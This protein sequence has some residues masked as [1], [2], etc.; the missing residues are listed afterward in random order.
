MPSLSVVMIVKDE[1]SRL[2]ECL[3]SVAAIAQEI[4]VGD[5]GSQD[6]TAEVARGHGAQVVDVP[7]END[8]AAARNRVLAEASGDWLL[9]LDADELVDPAGAAR[10]RELVDGDGFG[11][12]A[13]EVIL[14]NYCDEPRAWRWAPVEPDAPFARGRSGYIPVGL[15]RLFRNGRGFEYREAVHENI[16]ESVREYGGVVRAEPIVIHHHGL[17]GGARAAEK[18]QRYLAIAQGKVQARPADPKAWHDLAEQ[19]FACGMAGE[20]EEACAK[21]LAIDPLHLGA[22]TMIVNL[23][24]NRG[25]LDAA[26]ALL[27]KLEEAGITSPHVAIALGAIACKQGDPGQAR[28]RF[29]AVVSAEPRSIMG[30][31][32]LARALEQLGEPDAAREHLAAALDTAPRLDELQNR[33]AA[34]DL[35]RE[36]EAL[37]HAEDADGALA[38]LVKALRLDHEDPLTQNDLGVVLAAM[39]YSVQAR[40]CFRRALAL[41]PGMTDA[42]NNLEALETRERG[43]R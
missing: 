29:E 23:H 1:A 13:I 22:A 24:L 43:D 7:W 6:D 31:L 8:F 25:N 41:A 40:E 4:V 19:C 35:R 11:A 30:R 42:E 12:D 5:T 20:A 38:T 14:A 9:H 26:K 28:R 15:L 34:H 33:L 39:G 18:A 27:L 17:T 2:G 16:T 10:I 36:A 3:S 37:F 21:A 32:H